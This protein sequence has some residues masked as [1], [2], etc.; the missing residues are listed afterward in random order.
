M[1]RIARK[2][3][4]L[5]AILTPP[6]QS[7]RSAAS[8]LSFA[9]PFGRG[10]G[11]R[12]RSQRATCVRFSD[13]GWLLIIASLF[14]DPCRRTDG[15]HPSWSP[16]RLSGLREFSG[17]PGRSSYP[18]ATPRLFCGA[19]SFGLSLS[20]VFATVLRRICRSPSSPDPPPAATTQFR[21]D[22]RQDRQER[23]KLANASHSWLCR[24]Y[25][26]CQFGWLSSVSARCCFSMPI[27]LAGW[28]VAFHD[29]LCDHVASVR[30][31]RLCQYFCPIAQWQAF[32]H[33]QRIAGSKSP[34]P[35][36]S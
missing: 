26:V 16:L 8:G 15:T 21:A 36:S 22:Q 29:R 2:L 5:R 1:G 4:R 10:D 27:G 7:F 17:L 24:H 19:T 12:L 3:A 31:Q 32:I 20:F 23:W 14:Y 28:L 6:D 30:P 25:A 35:A 34:A 9:P 13:S 33:T 11:N 18:W